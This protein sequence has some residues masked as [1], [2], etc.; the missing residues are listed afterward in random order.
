[1]TDTTT[2]NEDR[3]H[4]TSPLEARRLY[5][6]QYAV[7]EL[8]ACLRNPTMNAMGR[9]QNGLEDLAAMDAWPHGA[10]CPVCE[11]WLPRD[12]TCTFCHCGCSQGLMPPSEWP[13]PKI[14]ESEI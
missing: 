1:M 10:A 9:I 14:W 12:T 2:T 4:L 3:W 7:Q 8:V 6:L 11:N 5:A 13:R